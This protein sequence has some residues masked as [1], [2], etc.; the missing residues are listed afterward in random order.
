MTARQLSDGGS[1][2]TVLGQNAADLVAFHGATPIIQ[3]TFIATIGATST[4][5]HFRA[6]FNRVTNLLARLGLTAA[7]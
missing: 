2:G 7:S 5:A 1:G 3:A 6:A 4:T